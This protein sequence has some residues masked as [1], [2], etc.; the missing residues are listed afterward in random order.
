[1]TDRSRQPAVLLRRIE[2]LEALLAEEEK[3]SEQ[4]R[5]SYRENLH[6]MVDCQMKLKRIEAALRGEE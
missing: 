5:I 1:M 4:Y 6:K 3:I 2:R